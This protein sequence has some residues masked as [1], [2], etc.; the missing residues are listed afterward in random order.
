MFEQTE[1]TE[2]LG[3]RV[4]SFSNHSKSPVSLFPLN[5]FSNTTFVKVYNCERRMSSN[6]FGFLMYG[7]MGVIAQI[8]LTPH[9]PPAPTYQPELQTFQPQN[10]DHLWIPGLRYRSPL[11][12]TKQRQFDPNPK[13]TAVSNY[14]V[15][16]ICKWSFHAI[17]KWNQ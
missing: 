8:R 7:S 16:W 13:M 5:L 15:D 2:S 17:N 6:V 14:K 12:S 11:L 1:Q 9:P 10:T 4:W 3:F